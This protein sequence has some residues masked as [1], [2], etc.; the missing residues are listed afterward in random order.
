[1]VT[2]N[3]TLLGG[4]P[5]S[6]TEPLYETA[7]CHSPPFAYAFCQANA[8]VPRD[9]LGADCPNLP[10]CSDSCYEPLPEVDIAPED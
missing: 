2:S 5:V 8:Q 1:M 3:L 9:A 4:F 7:W 6:T 10:P